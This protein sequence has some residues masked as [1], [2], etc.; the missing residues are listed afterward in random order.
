M[1]VRNQRKNVDYGLTNALQSIPPLPIIAQRD[2]T[3][4]D[5][6]E[7]GTEW[8][9]KSSDN[10]FI[11]TSIV[12]GSAVWKSGAGGGGD[13]TSITV[14]PGNITAVAGNIVA[15]AGSMSAGTTVTAGTGITATTGDIVAST[16]NITSTLGSVGAATT[17][18]AGTTITATLGDITATNGDFVAT[19]AGT[20][21]RFGAA[22]PQIL[23][24]AADPNG[25]V[26][27]TSGSLYLRSGTGSADTT[28]YVNT[29]GAQ[30]W[31]ALTS[32]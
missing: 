13:F 15:T 28:A 16:G 24:G 30:A 11:L 23:S 20:S 8:I 18:T 27:G 2:P 5:Y 17:V 12:A 4:A 3:A 7:L 32:T 22:G 21:F 25:S 19:A 6:A 9:N 26:T 14:N 10:F 29:N 1:A 31:T